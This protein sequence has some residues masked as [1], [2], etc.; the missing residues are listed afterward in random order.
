MPISSR[1]LANVSIS[2]ARAF[3]VINLNCVPCSDSRRFNM[4]IHLYLI[5]ASSAERLVYGNSVCLA[6]NVKE[7]LLNSADRR[8]YNCSSAIKSATVHH[9]PKVFC[10]KRI[11]TDKNRRKLLYSRLNSK[12]VSFE[13]RLTQATKPFVCS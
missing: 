6:L 3:F 12:S 1:T 4:C 10:A 9:L 11:L 8:H 7:R 5:A 13:N 2:S